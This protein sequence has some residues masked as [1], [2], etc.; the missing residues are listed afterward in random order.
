MT[1]IATDLPLVLLRLQKRIESLLYTSM[2]EEG[3][4]ENEITWMV[5]WENYQS[6]CEK[7]SLRVIRVFAVIA[8]T[9]CFFLIC[10]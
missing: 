1:G 4:K 10:F 3:M 5:S 2:F 8:F 6:S 7:I 9:V